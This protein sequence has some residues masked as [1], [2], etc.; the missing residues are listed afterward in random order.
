MAKC[1]KVNSPSGTKM[2]PT[3][4]K[5]VAPKTPKACA[6]KFILD[7]SMSLR[8]GVD[9][10]MFSHAKVILELLYSIHEKQRKLDRLKE[11]DQ[12]VPNSARIDFKFHM[13][14]TAADSEEFKTLLE[15]T[16]EKISEFE[17]YLKQQVMQAVEID[18][19]AKLDSLRKYFCETLALTA[20]GYIIINRVPKGMG[21]TDHRI[22]SNLFLQDDCKEA[23]SKHLPFEDENDFFDMYKE[24]HRL[25][26]FPFPR[27]SQN[28]PRDM[29]EDEPESSSNKDDRTG[30]TSNYFQ[31][32]KRQRT[33]DDQDHLN[34]QSTRDDESEVE[35]PLSNFE[36]RIQ[37]SMEIMYVEPFNVYLDR[38][39]KNKADLELKKLLSA[40]KME[41][42]THETQL[43]LDA[44]PTASREQL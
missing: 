17:L 16:K 24:F 9:N 34:T 42:V 29:D 39:E 8:E 1:T 22:V 25:D 5:E 7:Q 40:R 30:T 38:L 21:F 26:K 35:V 11:N 28:R 18:I 3:G 14:D 41:E 20:A 27:A 44:E 43:K 36:Y 10:M 33:N 19:A 4:K 13:S 2:K 32:K 6:N 23:L 15:E 31:D 37:R 12:L